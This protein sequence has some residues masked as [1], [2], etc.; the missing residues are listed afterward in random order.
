MVFSASLPL[1]SSF[2]KKPEEAAIGNQRGNVAWRLCPPAGCVSA[3][4]PWCVQ[5]VMSKEYAV[6][7]HHWV[8]VNMHLGPYMY[9]YVDL[10][11]MCIHVCVSV[12]V[13]L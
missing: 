1:G 4:C 3:E 9:V 11:C 2:S 10:M 8:W 12:C 7:C 13:L 6:Y 5:C